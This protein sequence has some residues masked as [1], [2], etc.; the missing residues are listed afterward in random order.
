VL[1]LEEKLQR[2]PLP[3]LREQMTFVVS[4]I[5]RGLMASDIAV[6]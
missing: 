4:T 6:T 2:I 5:G 1:G 3:V